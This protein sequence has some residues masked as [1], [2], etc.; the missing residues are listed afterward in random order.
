MMIFTHSNR[1]SSNLIYSDRR[2]SSRLFSI[3][4]ALY[5]FYLKRRSH[6]CWAGVSVPD[7]SPLPQIHVCFS[8]RTFCFRRLCPYSQRERPLIFVRAFNGFLTSLHHRYPLLL[9]LSAQVCSLIF[10]WHFPSPARTPR[11]L[12]VTVR[13]IHYLSYSVVTLLL[14]LL[15]AS[16]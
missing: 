11:A 8:S 16:W 7:L 1:E 12:H 3:L 2:L 10:I 6:V 15:C 4:A 9:T 14:P 5:W 13:A